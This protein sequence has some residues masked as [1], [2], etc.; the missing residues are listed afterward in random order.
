MCVCFLL[1]GCY[2]SIKAT[3]WYPRMADGTRAQEIRWLEDCYKRLKETSEQHSTELKELIPMVTALNLK[4]DQSVEK[5]KAI[6]DL[7]EVGGLILPTLGRGL[8][9]VCCMPILGIVN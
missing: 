3:P 7:T 6:G 5:S 4:F 9:R 2:I 1:P 8:P